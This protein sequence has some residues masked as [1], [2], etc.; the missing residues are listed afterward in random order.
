MSRTIFKYP[1]TL[2]LTTMSLPHGAI[3]RHV[4]VDPNEQLCLWAEIDQSYP[5]SSTPRTF[6]V[7]GTGSL[8]PDDA[9]LYL[10]TFSQGPLIWHVY[11][12]V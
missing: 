7:L 11:E 8:I 10:G 4:G 3:V 9:I 5:S 12:A 6:W 2:G 1:I